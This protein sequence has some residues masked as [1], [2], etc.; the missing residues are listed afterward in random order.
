[1]LLRQHHDSS[2]WNARE[3]RVLSLLLFT[4]MNH[5]VVSNTVIFE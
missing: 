5:G 4:M 3:K 1:M 2:W